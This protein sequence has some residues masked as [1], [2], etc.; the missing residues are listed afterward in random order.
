MNINRKWKVCK[1]CFAK[2]RKTYISPEDTSLFCFQS[3][4]VSYSQNLKEGEREEE[5]KREREEEG[6]RE[7]QREREEESCLKTNVCMHTNKSIN[8]YLITKRTD[9]KNGT[10]FCL[11]D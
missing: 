8:S 6:E 4:R 2:K 9:T 7:R 10:L 1:E 5:R 3:A 11:L